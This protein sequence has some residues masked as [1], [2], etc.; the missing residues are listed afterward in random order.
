MTHT[1]TTTLTFD[2]LAAQYDDELTDLRESWQEL[3]DWITDEHG[4]D[5]LKWNPTAASELD[6]EAMEQLAT[7]Q[8]TRH[9]Y[10]ESGKSIQERQHALRSLA[11][12][13]GPEPFEI[14][15]LTGQQL[16]EVET[17]LRMQANRRD[18]DVGLLQAQRRG[19]VVDA[20]TIGAPEGVPTDDDEGTPTPSECPNPITLS[21]YEQVERLNSAGTVDFRAPGFGDGAGSGR[22]SSSAT[23]RTSQQSPPS[24]D[25]NAP[26]SPGPG[27]S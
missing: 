24:L 21:L 23:P 27:N 14:Q 16:M 26:D 7:V 25:P 12:E 3:T 4:E 8:A 19:L 15:M 22:S 17:E 9:A 1:P 18:V 6:S 2:D 11:D 13:Y 20:A 5:A 10:D